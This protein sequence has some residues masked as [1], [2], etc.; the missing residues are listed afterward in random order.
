MA[1][2]SGATLG[3]VPCDSSCLATS[4]ACTA[5]GVVQVF[6]LH[7]NAT[8]AEAARADLWNSLRT[9]KSSRTI[10]EQQEFLKECIQARVVFFWLLLFDVL[11]SM[12]PAGR[13]ALTMLPAFLRTGWVASF[14]R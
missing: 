6:W 9:P 4:L 3:L 5:G 8:L 2:G 12:R 10:W 7:Y 13:K 1:S 11:F 14:L